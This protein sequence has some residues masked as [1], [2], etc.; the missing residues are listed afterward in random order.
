VQGINAHSMG[1]HDM[2]M[3]DEG[4]CCMCMRSMGTYIQYSVGVYGMGVLGEGVKNKYSHFNRHLRKSPYFSHHMLLN[5][6]MHMKR[7]RLVE[8]LKTTL[9]THPYRNPVN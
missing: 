4:V 6:F 9:L 5:H 7:W 2:S 8:N 3:H 1:V